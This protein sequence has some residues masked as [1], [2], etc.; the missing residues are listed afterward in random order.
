M[1]AFTPFFL[2][3]P[4]LGFAQRE[5][6]VINGKLQGLPNRIMIFLTD[7]NNPTDTLSQDS[8]KD[9]KFKLNGT[10]NEPN[11][12]YLNFGTGKKDL[13]FIGNDE[14]NISG[15]VEDVKNIVVAGSPSNADFDEFQKIFN[16]L[17]QQF[18][19][20]NNR[21]KATG[22]TDSLS[23][24]INSVYNNIHQQL[25][26][27]V[28]GHN[29]SYVSAFA[30]VVTAQV[31]DD[32]ILLEKRFYMLD[33]KVQKGYFGAYLKTMIDEAK[34]GAVGTDAIDFTQND[35]EGKPIKLSSLRG[36][37]VLLDFWASWCGPCRMENP[38]VVMAYNR[39]KE[40]NFTILGVSLDR[41]K[42]PWL[43]AISDDH[44]TWTQV[45][46]LKFWNNE[47]AQKYKIQ[48]IP[49]NFLIGPDG[50]IVAKNLRGPALESKLCELLGCN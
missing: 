23:K 6:F 40:K 14:I 39:F 17:F 45:S 19:D 12:Y 31:N 32:P 20:L 3:L 1:R 28:N 48:M 29:T 16:P 37:Y 5:S 2:L 24:Q 9:G 22:I 43:K 47:V 49:Q 30:L 27:F 25:D 8:A 7:A 13:L 11:L 38:N 34:V 35:V 50:K 36:K 21:A 44:L 4:L 10:I 41:A 26:A 18:T 15:N 42:E 33:E 46:D